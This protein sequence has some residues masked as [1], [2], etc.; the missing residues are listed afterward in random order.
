M[1]ETRTERK[2]N[3]VAPM[4]ATNAQIC[5]MGRDHT[6]FGDFSLMTNGY[7]VWISEQPIGAQRK[8]HIEMSKGQF[9]RLLR[10]YL[11]EAKLETHG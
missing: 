7:T 3:T 11:K 10:W 1:A 2:V 9:N 8:Q 6:E 4:N 5:W